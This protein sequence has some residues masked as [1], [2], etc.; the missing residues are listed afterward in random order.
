MGGGSSVRK[1]L[2]DEE[3]PWDGGKKQNQQR[4]CP[5]VQ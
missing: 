1:V 5:D 2:K 4:I 3:L